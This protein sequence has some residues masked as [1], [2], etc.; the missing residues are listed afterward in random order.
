M[1]DLK[2]EIDVNSI[3]SE[4]GEM[5]KD[6]SKDLKQAVGG[7]AS[8]THAKTLELA[9]QELGSL[10]K[11]YK[12]NVS[13]QQLEENI[14]VV[15]LDEKALWI[16]EGRKS[17][18]MEELLNGKSSKTS[19]SGEKYA[20]IPFE[21][22]KNPSEQSSRA[23]QLTNMIKDELKER[24][25]NYRKPEY[26]ADGSP[27]LGLIKRF[28]VES[29]KLKESHKDEP[30]K[31]VAIYQRM[32]KNTGKVRRDIM[33]FRVITER[34]REEGRWIHPGRAGDKLMDKAFEWAMNEWDSKILPE[35][36]AKYG[37]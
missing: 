32:D 21:H 10:Q 7:L 1:S 2:F 19:A 14:W 29:A 37:T 6:L 22:S 35:V 17:G 15:S 3:A 33:T 20:V 13:F 4:F 26:N 31:G 27:K 5:K 24:G 28:N 18:F 23:Q 11:M 34:H 12:D 8:M 36:L 16:E 25:I 30:L 9:T